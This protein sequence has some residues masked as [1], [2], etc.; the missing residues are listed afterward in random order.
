MFRTVKSAIR[1]LKL[2]GIRRTIHYSILRLSELWHENRLSIQTAWTVPLEKTNI[3]ENLRYGPIT[4]SAFRA[5]MKHVRV[6]PDSD[7]FVDFGAGKGRAVVLAATYPFKKVLGV[8]LA[9]ELAAVARDNVRRTRAKL[10]CPDVEIVTANATDFPIPDDSTVLHFVN[11]FRHKTLA[12]VVDR[13]RTSLVRKPRQVTILFAN[14]DDFERH[15]AEWS[16]ITHRQDVLWPHFEHTG[17]DS[18]RYRIYQLDAVHN[19]RS[20]TLPRK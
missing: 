3:G 11:P 9:P 7:V 15:I 19:C 1:H 17:P 2:H 13:I 14:P 8:E 6:I 4:Y 10:R 16:W 18:N 12:T 20:S 5:A